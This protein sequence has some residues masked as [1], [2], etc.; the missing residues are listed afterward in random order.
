MITAPTA[1]LLPVGTHSDPKEKVGSEG[2][3]PCAE[4]P[5]GNPVC[6]SD[7]AAGY[8]KETYDAGMVRFGQVWVD[9]QTKRMLWFAWA[10]VQALS[11]VREITYEPATQQLL[12]YPVAELEVL[13]DSTPLGSLPKT[14]LTAAKAVQLFTT[15]TSAFDVQA[16]IAL[17]STGG[18]ASLVAAIMVQRVPVAGE[19]IPVH[20]PP[21]SSIETASRLWT[22]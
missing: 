11:V 2:C 19:A 4:D 3:I 14:S 21:E 6:C 17:P 1:G 20:T 15:N 13:R 9:P 22:H 10:G 18:A 12:M 16:A 5:E 7:L 8:H